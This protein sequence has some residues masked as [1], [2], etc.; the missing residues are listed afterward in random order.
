MGPV[1]INPMKQQLIGVKKYTVQEKK[2]VK[3]IRTV[4]RVEYDERLM[5]E[6]NLKVEGWVERLYADYEGKYVREGEPLFKLYSPELLNAQ[7]EYLLTTSGRTSSSLKSSAKTKLL[8][9][10]IS[11]S[12]INQ[13]E[14]SKKP[15]T[16]LDILSPASGYI[17]SKSI[18]EG[19]HVKPGQTLLQ[20][21]DIKKVWILGDIYENELPFIKLG[22]NVKITSQSFAGRY[23]SGTIAYIYPNLNPKTR[24][25]KIRIEMENPEEILKPGMFTNIQIEV[26]KGSHL[27]VP[28]SAV[29]NSGV[30]KVVFVS[31]GNG[32]FIPNEVDT[33]PLINGYYPIQ[34][35]LAKG[36]VVV[37]SAN[38]FLDSESQLIA[39][40]EGMMGLIGMGDWKM[41]HSRMGE[42]DMGGMPGMKMNTGSDSKNEGAMNM[43]AG[44]KAKGE[45][46]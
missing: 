22:Q 33:G 6:V 16:R 34:N 10:D 39:S 7:E 1:M 35:G 37:S 4:G 9:W 25:V 36:D 32:I 46:E 14:K 43:P 29:L 30:R 13:L 21:A 27:A 44:D 31:K 8:L 17:I 3:T 19:G 2:L 18:I 5:R 38:F 26:E 24:S 41:E 42:M 40:M 11:E 28:E 23:Y 15:T 20:I 12:Q 45:T